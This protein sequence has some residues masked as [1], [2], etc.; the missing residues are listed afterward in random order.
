AGPVALRL[1]ARRDDAAPPLV[2]VG[3]PAGVDAAHVAAVEAELQRHLPRFAGR[4][5]LL[6]LRA[7]DRDV[8]VRRLDPMVA[9]MR[10]TVPMAAAATLVFRGPD[11]EGRPHFE[12]LHSRVPALP[13]GATFADPRVR[14]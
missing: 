9:M 12:A 6:V 14:P 4:A 5:V 8:P 3:V 13:A 1:L 2:V 11:E 10:R 7:G